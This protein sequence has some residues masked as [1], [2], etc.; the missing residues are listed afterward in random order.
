MN[1]KALISVIVPVYNVEKY[2]EKCLDSIINQTYKNIEI[3]LIDDGSTDSSGKI[4]DDY[5]KQDKR[6][7]VFHKENGGLSSARNYGVDKSKGEYLTFIDSDDIIELDYIDYLF[8]LIKKYDVELSI[9]PYTVIINNTKKYN[10]GKNNIEE[11]MDTERCLKRMLC[12]EGFTVSA[13]AKMYKKSLFDDI[14]FPVN[15]L[16]EDNGTTYKLM[17]KCDNIAYG[18]ISKYN[19]FKR[20]NSIM[21]S[22]FNIK[23]MDLLDLTDT[24]CDDIEKKYPN[25]IDACNKRRVHARFSIL[26][27]MTNCELTEDERLKQ[28]EIVKYLKQNRKKIFINKVFDKRDKM[29]ML[30]LLFGHKTFELCWNVYDRIRN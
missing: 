11:L 2:I 9:C 23:R 17:F 26:R 14:K 30:S 6:I 5:S 8:G 4:C 12:E 16:C 1:E 10:F 25:I 18:N 29:A 22:K 27:Q 21:T 20:P 13:C 24:M 19:Y 7:K 15:K 3:L 28:K